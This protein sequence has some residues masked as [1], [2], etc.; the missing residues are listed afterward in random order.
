MLHPSARLIAASL[1][2]VIATVPTSAQ[3]PRDARVQVTVVDPSGLIVPG[4]TVTLVRLESATQAVTIPPT[5]SNE[6]GIAVLERVT[7]GR[8]SVRGE[9]PGFDLGLL[10]DVR[11]AATQLH[12]Y[13]STRNMAKMLREKIMSLAGRG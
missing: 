1:L 6:K 7:P 10:R 4:A 5:K 9:F 3:T 13:R 8:Y 12:M 11:Q 2:A